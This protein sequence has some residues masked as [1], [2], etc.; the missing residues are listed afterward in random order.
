MEKSEYRFK[1]FIT[2]SFEWVRSFY[3]YNWII[4]GLRAFSLCFVCVNNA[5]CVAA[6]LMF[7]SVYWFWISVL[8]L[9]LLLLTYHPHHWVDRDSTV[10]IA[11]RYGLDGP[12]I[13][14]RWG[15]HFLHPSWPA[16]RV[17]QAPMQGVPGI[18]LEGKAV[19]VW[20]WPPAP[21]SAE[22]KERAE[23]YLYSPSGPSWPVL[24]WPLPFTSSLCF[25]CSFPVKI[26]MAF[27]PYV[28]SFYFWVLIL[29]LFL[30][31]PCYLVHHVLR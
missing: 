1:G 19:G 6:Y 11:T 17:T 28:A 23:L 27:F 7:V 2:L 24:G 25:S 4:T 9:L 15:R 18:L 22:V 16:L 26:V 3:S 20:R 8:L 21:S 14:S 10:G 12:G 29:R 30:Y 13:E 31:L 5:P